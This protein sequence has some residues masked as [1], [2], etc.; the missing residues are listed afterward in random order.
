MRTYKF[1]FIMMRNI[2][3]IIRMAV[4]VL[5]ITTISCG[6]S[7]MNIPIEKTTGIPQQVTVTD[8]K[9]VSGAT[10]I[11]YAVPND[12]RV[13]YIEAVYEIKGVETKR[14]GSFYTNSLTLDGFPE[15]KEYQVALYSVSHSETRS[16]PV[17]VTVHPL[18]P[19]YIDVATTLDVRS[20]PGGVKSYFQ[21]PTKS[22]LQ[23]TFLELQ[24]NGRWREVETVYTSGESGT[25]N[26]RGLQ[27]REYIFGVVCRDRWQNVSDT[28]RVSATPGIEVKADHTKIKSYPLPTDITYEYPKS[29]MLVNHTGPT[30]ATTIDCLWDGEATAPFTTNKYLFI[31]NISTGHPYSGLPSSITLDLGQNFL[32]TRFVHRVRSGSTGMNATHTY[33]GTHPKIFE[34]W[35]S[36]NP[37]ADGSYSSWTKL[38][39]FES[40][41]ASGNTA[42]G[43]A[44]S[45]AEDRRI[46]ELGES[47]EMPSDIQ[48]YR[49]YRYK[50][51]EAWGG[52]QYWAA[53]ELEF[54]GQP[55]N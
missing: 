19:P 36:N 1:N 9:N 21:N 27:P 39:L 16:E 22:P 48:P 53:S 35:G 34:L 45:T 47:F 11:T 29:G 42:P 30:G 24:S 41:R 2:T 7:D 37:S 38:G 20:A 40:V 51:F 43:N 44:N 14:K 12:K 13:A 28:I 54:Y 31:Q 52:T 46:Y 55:M 10:T 26:V 18:T 3:S 50:V 23:I 15:S 5:L 32:L 49:Y 8:V 25:I 17:I 6:R 33:D 4:M